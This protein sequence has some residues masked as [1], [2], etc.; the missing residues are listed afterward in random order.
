AHLPA[1]RAGVVLRALRRAGGIH[2]VAAVGALLPRAVAP[3]ARGDAHGR[4]ALLRGWALQRHAHAGDGQS[5]RDVPQATGK[6]HRERD[7]NNSFP[8][9][10]DGMCA[11]LRSEVLPRLD[12]EFARG[13][14]FGVINLLNTLKVRAS[15]SEG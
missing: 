13:Q 3:Q 1:R 5:D 6:D 2:G 15:W 7:M 9:L 4:G 10:I 12:D 8:R 14:V 11:T